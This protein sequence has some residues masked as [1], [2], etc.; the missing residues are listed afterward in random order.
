MKTNYTLLYDE[1]CPLCAWYTGLFLKTGM[2]NEKGRKAYQTIN[3]ENYPN[4]DLELAKNKIACVNQENG[5]VV[6]GIDSLLTILGQ[7]FPLIQKIGSW[8]VVHY[9]LEI[10]YNFISFNRKIFASTPKQ[11]IECACEPSRSWTYRIAFVLIFS[12]LTHFIVTAY[13]HKNLSDFLIHSEVKDGYLLLAQ[14]IVQF[15]AF[16]LFKQENAYDYLA[17]V[18]FVSFLGA[19]G[20]A[21]GQIV[22]NVFSY[23]NQNTELLGS[24]FYGMVFMLMFFEH[25]RRVKN[26]KWT[27]KL[28]LTWILFRVIIYFFVFI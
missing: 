8:K 9:L 19:L 23:F 16:K 7:R 27:W 12:L 24:V 1:H 21:S 22:L 20:L 15:I 14:L 6:Y 28:S 25:K 3:S 18:C 4:V 5:Q 10:L 2:L 17:H 26:N 11:E 13:F